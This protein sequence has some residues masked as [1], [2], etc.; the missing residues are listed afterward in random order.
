VTRT[1]T[2][3]VHD[4]RPPE[5]LVKAT[6]PL[7]RAIVRSPAGRGIGALTVLEYHGRRSGAR[8]RVVAAWHQYDGRDFVLTPAPWRANFSDPAPARMTHRGHTRSM[9]GTLDRDPASVAAVLESCLAAGASPGSFGLAVEPGHAVTGDDVV[10][11]RR[12]IV[13]LDPAGA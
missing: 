12:A 1:D 7:V 3:A 10:H 6:N 13:W 2:G 8:R 9:T 5:R 11:V 4:A